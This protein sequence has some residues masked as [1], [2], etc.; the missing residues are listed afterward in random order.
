MCAMIDMSVDLSG[1]QVLTLLSL[2]LA[3]GFGNTSQ[4][5]AVQ[6]ECRKRCELELLE[7]LAHLERFSLQ[8]QTFVTSYS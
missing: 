2:G 5:I 1:R 7:H 4:G 8:K 6:R 3:H